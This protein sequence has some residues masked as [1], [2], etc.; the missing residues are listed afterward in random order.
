MPLMDFNLGIE[1][2][3]HVPWAC[4]GPEVGVGPVLKRWCF[5]DSLGV[6]LAIFFVMQIWIF[7]MTGNLTW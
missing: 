7:C 3:A 6:L 1:P 5:E 4:P 2:W